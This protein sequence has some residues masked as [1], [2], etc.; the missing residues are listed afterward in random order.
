MD[1]A[2]TVFFIPEISSV[3]F[4][5]FIKYSKGWSNKHA[6]LFIEEQTVA[7]V[8]IQFPSFAVIKAI[9]TLGNRNSNRNSKDEC[10]PVDDVEDKE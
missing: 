9:A 4:L 6:G 10:Q 5:I 3:L 7:G 1:L 8:I 2:Y